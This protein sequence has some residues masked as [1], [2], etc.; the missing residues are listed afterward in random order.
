MMS[1][2]QKVQ[3]KTYVDEVVEL[4][5]N[6]WWVYRRTVDFN[7]TMSPTPRIVF[8]ANSRDAVDQWMAKQN[9]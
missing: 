8:F 4:D 6:S 5:N 3:Q 9:S 7:G 2:L 1:P